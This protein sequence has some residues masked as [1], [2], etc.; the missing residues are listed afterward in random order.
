MAKKIKIKVKVRHTRQADH[1][2]ATT[3]TP[4]KTFRVQLE[5]P[6]L[7]G[8]GTIQNLLHGFK[9]D[10]VLIH[11]AAGAVRA[12][13]YHKRDQH[14]VYLLSGSMIY[15]DR[16]KGAKTPPTGIVVGE[17]QMIHTPANCEHAMLFLEPTIMLALTKSSRRAVDYDKEIV[18]LTELLDPETA[19]FGEAP[20]HRPAVLANTDNRWTS[21]L[22][23]WQRL[24]RP[25]DAVLS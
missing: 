24:T 25:L 13:H 2:T 19:V 4:Q 7:D 1:G 23:L 15:L 22:A 12:Q 8:R 14:S 20:G 18:K 21:A 9:G 3:A 5:A 10:V 17:D 11:S 16:P 6:F